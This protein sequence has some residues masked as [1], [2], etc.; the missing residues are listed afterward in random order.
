MVKPLP[1]FLLTFAAL[2]LAVGAIM[3]ASAFKKIVSAVT[4]S[5]L[6][7]FAAGSLK[8]L[9]LGDSA[10]LMLL[11]AVFAFIVARPSAATR[12]IVVILS[13]IP[14]S[15]AILIYTF[16]GSFIGGHVLIVAAI[17][18]FVGGLQYPSTSSSSQSGFP[19]G[20]F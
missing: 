16:I 9:W 7:V 19:I 15:T 18:A 20:R 2:V 10:T 4:D 11:A 13:L 8:L 17:A 5:N 12:W 6:E 3:H 1:R 14:A